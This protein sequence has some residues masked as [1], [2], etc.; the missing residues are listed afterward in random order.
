MSVAVVAGASGFLGQA[1][2]RGLRS[3]G[4]DVLGIDVRP[5]PHVTV[6]D[7]TRSGAWTE[8][9]GEADLVVNAAIMGVESGHPSAFWQVN[10]EG[11]RT[12]LAEAGRAGVDRVLHLSSTVVHGTDFA[13]GADETDPV[14]MTGNPY[15]DTTVS[16]EHQALLAHA[17]GLVSVTVARLG[18]VYGPHAPMWTVRP[19]ELM[20]R[21]LFVLFDGGKGLVSPTYIDDAVDG[22]LAAATNEDGA[23]HVFHVT[24][25][26]TVTAR[27]FFEHYAAMLG[28]SLRS[29]P[30]LAARLISTP[31]DIVSRNLG[32]QPPL[33]PRAVELFSHPGGYSI[34]KAETML[35]WAPGVPLEEGMERTRGWLID[36][37][38]V[39]REGDG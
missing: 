2:A 24:G 4:W 26:E 6:G 29:L 5:G 18:D 31:V 3:R 38:L 23:G 12:V 19:V 9:L 7:V 20:R 1:F 15:T 33:H 39:P 16:A 8:L 21:N 22:A 28:M 37:G 14:R 25:G 27:E 36:A 11:A 32:W 34:T 17:S 13:D 35:G 30:G 10:V